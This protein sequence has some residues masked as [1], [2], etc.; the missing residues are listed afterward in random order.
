MDLRPRSRSLSGR[1]A[2]LAIGSMHKHATAKGYFN[3]T[4]TYFI[5]NVA[6]ILDRIRSKADA[7]GLL[8]DNSSDCIAFVRHPYG[9]TADEQTS[10]GLFERKWGSNFI[11]QC[12][13]DICY[14][15]FAERVRTKV[16]GEKQPGASG[17][18]S[19]GRA[20][21]TRATRGKR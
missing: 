8:T 15:W 9:F 2:E 14:N 19:T 3:L 18:R 4:E 5:S 11:R 21:G 6:D 10:G 12:S 1:I 13:S 17:S 16:R 7:L 20:T